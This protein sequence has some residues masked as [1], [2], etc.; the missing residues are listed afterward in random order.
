[1]SNAILAVP[2]YRQG[3]E[4]LRFDLARV[5]E[6]EARLQD[7]Q[8]AGTSQAKELFAVFTKAYVQLGRVHAKVKYE[9]A[10]AAIASRKRRAVLM[11]DVIPEKAKEKGLGTARAPTGS[12]DVREAFMYSDSDFLRVEESRASLE[13]TLELVFGKMM[14]M[15]D[16]MAACRMMLAPGDVPSVQ[17]LGNTSPEPAEKTISYDPEPS[18]APAT[19]KGGWAQ[20]KHEE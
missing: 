18:P 8:L 13:A 4:P 6:A 16:A 17:T 9:V 15:K 10:M 2:H 3:I 11:L 20:P 19:R 14:A 1:M 12:E 5:Y 7:I